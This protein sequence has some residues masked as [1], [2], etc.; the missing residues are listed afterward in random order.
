V[1]RIG[2]L[3]LSL[4]GCA[5]CTA[6]IEMEPFPQE[7]RPAARLIGHIEAPDVNPD[8]LPKALTPADPAETRA[9]TLRYHCQVSY[10]PIDVNER[11]DP[12]PV[13]GFRKLGID[14]I[15]QGFLEIERP[16]AD[17]RTLSEQCTV[18]MRRS[19]W[20]DV[21]TNTD[22]REIGLRCVRDLFDDRIAAAAAKRP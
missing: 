2:S 20:G 22:L 8:Y 3:L 4:L 16:D 12:L 5:A 21:P 18:Y 10:E 7:T 17:P 15:A 6:T 1:S 11:Y 9:P 14:V 13:L 19:V